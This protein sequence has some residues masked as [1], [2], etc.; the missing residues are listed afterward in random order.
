MTVL[1]TPA[2]TYQLLALCDGWLNTGDLGV[3]DR[4]G[5]VYLTGRAKDLII[6]GGHNIDPRVIEDVL[7]SHPAVVI[8]SGATQSRADYARTIEI[9]SSLRSSQ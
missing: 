2:S 1:P 6:R 8:A 9:A 5:Y 4:N 3:V 7:L